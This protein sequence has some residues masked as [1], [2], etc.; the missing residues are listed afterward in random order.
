MTNALLWSFLNPV[1]E[2]GRNRLDAVLSPVQTEAAIRVVGVADL[3]TVC[4]TS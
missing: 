1:D 2:V 4:S 3:T